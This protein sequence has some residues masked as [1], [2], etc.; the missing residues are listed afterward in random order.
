MIEI[1][2]FYELLLSD[3]NKSSLIFKQLV[4]SFNE[5]QIKDISYVINEI[6]SK[7]ERLPERFISSYLKFMQDLLLKEVLNHD[8]QVMF[9]K[10]SE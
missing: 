2:N 10:N 7:S 5:K 9:A 1:L 6:D 4:Q 8:K 3:I